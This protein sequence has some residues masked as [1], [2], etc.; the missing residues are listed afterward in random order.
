M[1]MLTLDWGQVAGIGNPM[2]TP[3]WATANVLGGFIGFIWVLAP[4]LY[5]SNAYFFSVS[6][7]HDGHR[8]QK[9]YCRN[10]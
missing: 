1:S 4:I 5:Y 8:M 2:A 7:F 9:A 6:A 3:W 10:A